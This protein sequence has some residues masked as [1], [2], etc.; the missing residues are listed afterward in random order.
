MRW[1]V[2]CPLALLCAT[3]AF[4]QN[5]STSFPLTENPISESGKWNTAATQNPYM[6]STPGF[7]FG[8]WTS[9]QT[10]A[11]AILTG[12]W[13]RIQQIQGTVH[14]GT[15]PNGS[16]THEVELHVLM[17]ACGT[18][19]WCGYEINCSVSSGFSYLQIVRWD[20]SSYTYI[21][22]SDTTDRCNN[23]DV[24][25]AAVN[26]SGVITVY[27]NGT[28][29]IQGTDTTYTSG[30]PGIGTWNTDSTNSYGFSSVVASSGTTVYVTPSGTATGNC[31]AGT[32][33]APNLTPAQFNQNSSPVVWGTGAGQIGPGTTV[34]VCGT[35]NFAA[36][37]TSAFTFQGGGT[38]G[39]SIVML[40]DAGSIIEA[41]WWNGA[42]I[43]LNGYSF[44]T[45]NGQNSGQILATLAGGTGATC[46]GGPCQYQ[47]S[48]GS[49]GVSGQPGG[50][51]IAFI[52]IECGPMYVHYCPSGVEAN[53]PD[54]GGGNTSGFFVADSNNVTI[55]GNSIQ[56]A[57]S[58]IT[59]GSDVNGSCSNINMS[60]NQIFF[61]NIGIQVANG[62]TTGSISGIIA[63]GN[64]IHDGANWTDQANNNH[65]DGM[66]FFTQPSGPNTSTINNPQIA[67]NFF[68]GVWGNGIN[69]LG[70]FLEG[71]GGT[72]TGD[73]ISPQIFNNIIESDDTVAHNGNGDV[74]V[75]NASSPLIV[76]NTLNGFTCWDLFSD[77]S[78]TIE[79]NIAGNC[80]FFAIHSANPST[81][82]EWDYNTYFNVTNWDNNATTLAGWRSDCAADFGISCDSHS[83]YGIP[84]FSNPAV[85]TLPVSTPTATYYEPT[86]SATTII[87]QGQNLTNL[88]VPALDFDFASAARPS[89]TCSSQGSSSCWDLGAYAYGGV[90]VSPPPPPPPPSAPTGLTATV[91]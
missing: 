21:N 42:V 8:N 75:R 58:G 73:F 89:G 16:D 62:R 39:N 47:S 71:G 60:D 65:H 22:N 53:C 38:S 31:P 84:G 54:E 3:G 49:C 4:A 56:G 76:N 44:I 17:S 2:L 35:Y 81:V 36:G 70:P 90:G 40:L 68:Y 61:I 87:E 80:Y 26:S 18:N 45:V 78:V 57:W 33:S 29:K 67:G 74:S 48:G 25:T 19:G 51:N 85:V 7:A 66:H 64:L 79:N 59:Y 41:P 43:N 52:N 86:S 23:G 83:T 9:G 88:G 14:I 69:T 46:P 50:N 30:N 6:Q 11:I 20:P 5:Y 91:E 24:L 32:P 77:A 10:D 12:T 34:L 13:S 1:S 27:I 28:Q 37:T 55:T 72:E 15:T 63:N 82:T